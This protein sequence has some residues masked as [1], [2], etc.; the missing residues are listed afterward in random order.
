MYRLNKSGVFNVPYN[1]NSDAKFDIENIALISNYFNNS[2][3]DICCGDFESFCKT[4]KSGDFVYFDSPYVPE[5]KTSNFTSYTEFGFSYIDHE[6]L[7]DLYKYLDKIGAYVMLSN[8]DVP[9]V[10]DMYSEFNIESV[11]AR[12]SINRNGNKRIG[13]EVI[14]TNYD[15][16]VITNR[17]RLF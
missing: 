10:R 15:Y 8:N 14:V 3:V 13:K 11:C 16:R 9:Y 6:R 12:R 5:S 17:K 1:G 2:M 7:C 4:V